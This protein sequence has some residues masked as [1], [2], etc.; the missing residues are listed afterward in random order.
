MAQ[1]GYGCSLWA[2]RLGMCNLRGD[3]KG[4][5]S[6]GLLL[7]SLATL[8]LGVSPTGT[9]MQRSRGN[10]YRTIYH[11][12]RYIT[13]V[14]QGRLASASQ[15]SSLSIHQTPRRMMVVAGKAS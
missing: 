14:W 1:G 10:G 2:Q 8:V 3:G 5:D 7:V 12:P 6:Q 13:L 9:N 15:F 4:S 11:W